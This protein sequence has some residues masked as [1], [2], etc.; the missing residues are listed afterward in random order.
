M[1]AFRRSAAA[2]VIGLRWLLLA[3]V[4]FLSLHQ[5]GREGDFGWSGFRQLALPVVD[6]R[7]PAALLWW[8]L[9][10][11][12]LVLVAVPLA[13][14]I[15][16]WLPVGGRCRTLAIGAL[17][18]GLGTRGVVGPLVMR[19]ACASP[20]A[21]LPG[22]GEAV[23]SW[24]AS[25]YGARWIVALADLW[26]LLPA[27]V[28]L[29]RLLGPG[30][31]A[32]CRIIYGLLAGWALLQP[33]EAAYLLTAGGP[34]GATMSLS[35]LAVTEGFGRNELG[36]ASALALLL[37]LASL[38]FG[39]WVERLAPAAEVPAGATVRAVGCRWRLLGLLSLVPLL[40]AWLRNPPGAV[41]GLLPLA[42]AVS[43]A[44]TATAAV[45]TVLLATA[46]PA[47]PRNDRVATFL[48]TGALFLPSL[49]LVLPMIR[50][51]GYRMGAAEV[52]ALAAGMVVFAPYLGLAWLV[53]RLVRGRASHG[54]AVAAAAAV[55]AWGTWTDL[56]LPV[57]LSVR[58]HP[59]LPL[60]GRIVWELSTR[61]EA[62]PLS[63]PGWPLA[64]VLGSGLAGWAVAA[65]LRTELESR[66]GPE[67]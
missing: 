60:Q 31:R 18:V 64:W 27:L 7:V 63:V 30:W 46:L 21:F 47:N 19:A 5:W 24:L 10:T 2:V 37:G 49:V 41:P 40:F 29:L 38:P 26:W 4:A 66:S 28:V 35:L 62:S 20:A 50:P 48:R 13:D 39:A 67:A 17:A 43:L 8:L 32:H 44:I 56:S 61:W 12:V 52:V 14:R 34:P 11:A 65:V 25:P 54:A 57:L 36:Y 59:L 58:S 42:A 51:W 22:G 33:G 53:L 15:A 55:V 1:N 3:A 23:R 6:P 9:E 16:R 45:W